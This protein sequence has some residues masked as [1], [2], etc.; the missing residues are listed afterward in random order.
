MV[1][2]QLKCGA[3]TVRNLER[4]VALEWLETNAAGD[5]ACGT[6]AGPATRR[7]HGLFV[8]RG[9]GE[10]P[11]LLLAELDAVLETGETSVELSCHQYVGVRRPEGWRHGLS[12]EAAPFPTWRHETP[13]GILTTRL[14][15]PHDSRCVCVV[16][17]LESDGPPSPCRLRVRPLMAYRELHALTHANLDADLAWRKDGNAV[18]IAPYAGCPR[19]IFHAPGARV[20]DARDWYYRFHHPWD[21]EN[22][23]DGDEDRFCFCEFFYEIAPGRDAALTAGFETSPFDVAEAALRETK[24]REVFALPGLDADPLA[25]TLARAADA[26][27][28]C[29]ADGGADIV[30]GY[31]G[32]YRDDLRARLIA[33]PG[34]LLSTRRLDDAKDFLNGALCDLLARPAPEE[35]DDVGLWLIRAGEQYVDHSRDWDFLRETL[36]PAAR[37]IAERYIRNDSAT[38]F[39][40][41]PD[42]LLCSIDPSRALTWMDAC[43]HDWPATPRTGKP[44]E[45][46]ALWHHT[47]CLLARW[48][49]RGDDT[50]A[51][52][53]FSRLRDLCG[54]SFRLRFWHAGER[55]LR[56]VVD[57]PADGPTTDAVRPNQIIAVAL[58]SD[59]LDRAQAADV[60]AFVE[61]RLLTPAGLRTLSLEDPAFRP[62]YG[63]GEIE[64]EAAR[65]QGC[66]AP[67]LSGA[68]VDAVFRVNGRTSRAYA[69]AEAAIGELLPA[70]LGQACLGHVSET[71]DGG[72]PHAARGAFAHAPALGELVRSYAEVRGR[73]W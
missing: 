56:D 4:S 9:P 31:P 45:V 20:Q 32:G 72:A 59:L 37:E 49:R 42:A 63:G 69:R 46:N 10:M 54:R 36:A 2:R 23:L 65:H 62:R 73:I 61:K 11:M 18:S 44:V 57:S 28:R 8:P 6:V 38:G 47:L 34:I 21:V 5:F 35:L 7:E 68:Y 33:L 70:H 1:L 71:F 41:T 67:W 51:V 50:A 24:R 39:R 22:G 14:F 16:W 12:F 55:R 52:E 40:M 25:Q 3:E 53:R 15:L 58:P 64:R 60:L 19:M 17:R 29:D 66:V 30:V 43:I 26:F 27:V 13:A 48:L